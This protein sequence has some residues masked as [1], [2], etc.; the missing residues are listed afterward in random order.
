MGRGAEDD[1]Q[2]RSA[3]SAQHGG[4]GSTC[5]A[6]VELGAVFQREETNVDGRGLGIC[7]R[8]LAKRER[9]ASFPRQKLPGKP[10]N[11]RGDYRG[12]S[13]APEDGCETSGA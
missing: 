7:S 3:K 5:D 11:Q 2:M 6:R 10:V 12:D 4:S 13:T 8:V 9:G 1:L